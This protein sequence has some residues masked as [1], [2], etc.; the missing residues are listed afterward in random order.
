MAIAAFGP[1]VAGQGYVV[2]MDTSLVIAAVLLMATMLASLRL[3][4]AGH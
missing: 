3:R 2:G 1:L 4:G